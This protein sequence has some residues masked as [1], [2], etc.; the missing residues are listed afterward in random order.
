VRFV[1][2]GGEVTPQVTAVEAGPWMDVAGTFCDDG[3]RD[4]VAILCHP[5]LPEHPPRWILRARRSMQNPAYPG[6]EPVALSTTEPLVL[7]YAL[8]LHRG[9]TEE[10]RIDEAYQEYA[11]RAN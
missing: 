1:S 2:D 7:R 4:G 8:L 5:T 6:R 9:A 11:K 10:A 3:S